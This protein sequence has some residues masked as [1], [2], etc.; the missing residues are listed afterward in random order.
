MQTLGIN[1]LVNFDTLIENKLNLDTWFIL[2][3]LST[4]NLRLVDAYIDNCGT[5]DYKTLLLGEKEGYIE[6]DKTNKNITLSSV[7]ITPKGKSIIEKA[8]LNSE[9]VF[10]NCF[11]QLRD[12]Y[13]KRVPGENGTTRPLHG[14][15]SRCKK[16]YLKILSSDKSINIELHKKILK[17]I[18]IEVQE[19]NKGRRLPFMQNLVTYLHQQ[20]FLQYLDVDK[21]EIK[22]SDNDNKTLLGNENF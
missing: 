5:I 11:Q 4:N 2:Y 21:E 6:L 13:P 15:L 19:R 22:T 8:T 7:K 14:D 10:N 3:C 17:A 9:E 18:S 1:L 12:T 20:N 16:L